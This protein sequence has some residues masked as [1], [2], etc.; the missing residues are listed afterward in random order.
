MPELK[1]MIGGREFEV[2]CQEGE[3]HFLRSAARLLDNEAQVLVSQIGRMPE[4]RLLLMAGLMLADKA[5]GLDDQLRMAE[6]RAMV[7]E[8][9]AADARAHPER[10]E[11]PVIPDIV[12]DTFSEIAARAEALAERMEERLSA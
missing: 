9:V 1:V 3:E 12:T 11:V 10:I 7:A 8:R 2:A 5:A 4:V 6:E